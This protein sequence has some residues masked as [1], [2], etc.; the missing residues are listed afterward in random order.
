MA[1]SGKSFTAH[2]WERSLPQ[3]LMR[4]FGDTL[5]KGTQT[6]IKVSETSL[7]KSLLVFLLSYG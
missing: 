4:R 3:I 5:W 2:G 7:G 1:S 6:V